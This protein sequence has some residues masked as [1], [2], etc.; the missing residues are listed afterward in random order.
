VSDRYNKGVSGTYYKKGEWNAICQRCGRKYKASQLTQE[1]DLLY[2]CKDCYED[3]HPQDMVRGVVD[4]QA[5]PWSSPELQD[6]F[7]IDA[8]ITGLTQADFAPGSEVLWDDAN[9]L[10]VM[11]SGGSLSSA[12]DLDVMN[13]ANLCAVMNSTGTWEVLQ[14]GTAT[15]TGPA[16]YT[17]THL[18]RAR[19]ETE[20]AMN[21][22]TLPAKS[23][24][25]FIG[26]ASASNDIWI[27]GYL[28]WLILPVSPVDISAVANGNG[29]RVFSWVRRSRLPGLWQDDWSDQN[30]MA[31]LDEIDERYE[32]DILDALGAPIRTLHAV[33]HPSATYPRT[34]QIEDFGAIQGAYTITVYQVDQILGRGQGRT[35]TVTA[36]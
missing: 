15:L 5:T 10:V 20:G 29:D 19:Y 16:T 3:R 17:L 35:A 6:S 22:G 4:Q 1:W 2:V 28:N 11:V 14:F 23:P 21:V 8:T 30:F 9:P 34:N 25:V 13:G 36:Q 27:R 7:L 24:F 12:S 26:Q 18:L 33:G 31:P 32:V